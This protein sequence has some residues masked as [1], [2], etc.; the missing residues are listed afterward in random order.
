MLRF[1]EWRWPD[2]GYSWLLPEFEKQSLCEI[3][4][5][6]EVS[7][8]ERTARMFA[9]NPHVYIPRVFK[10]MSCRKVIVM[11]Y[12]DGC[13]VSACPFLSAALMARA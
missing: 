11:E 10:E 9:E 3:D 1:I 13:K 6:Q 5:L 2:Y 7:N 8:A 4:F 12:I